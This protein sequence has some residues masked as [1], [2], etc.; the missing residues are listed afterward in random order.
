MARTCAS[1]SVEPRERDLRCPSE[2][3]QPNRVRMPSARRRNV[4][5]RSVRLLRDL[6]P[7]E[8]LARVFGKLNSVLTAS[9]ADSLVAFEDAAAVDWTNPHPTES[10]APATAQVG[11]G[12]LHLAWIMSPPGRESG[13]HQ[14]LFRFIDQAERHGH[15]CTI[16]L[17]DA[18]KASTISDVRATIESSDA[19]AGVAAD[20][21][22][23]VR[24]VGVDAD[25]DAI[26]ATGWETAYP[27]YLDA[28]SARRLYFVQD[29]EPSFYPM[30]SNYVLAENTYR[31]G[32]HGIT[33]G[34]W[35]AEKLSTEYGMA[36]DKFDFAVDKS[37]YWLTNQQAR[38]EVFFYARPVTARRAFEFGLMALS[39]FSRLRPDVTINFAGWHVNPVDVPFPFVNHGS[40][41]LKALNELYNRCAAGLVLSLTNMSLLPLELMSSGV[42][43]VV[44]DA[45][46]NRLVADN[47]FIE[48]VPLAPSV[49]AQRMAGV[50]ERADGAA[51]LTRMSASVAEANWD[52]S[53]DAFVSA[54]ERAVR[55]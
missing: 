8:F 39:E 34:G 37:K 52:D 10:A 40:L 36:T 24:S 19:Y 11:S 46:N 5:S 13:G 32:F 17:Y 55:G 6:G 35:L 54:V 51:R 53:G 20:I 12:G 7:R 43:P 23:Y 45:P 21:R 31:F 28:S 48:W 15:R 4:I 1:S 2:R 29:F 16:Y 25:T 38:S 27:S 26:I 18:H 22:V 9:K 33:A 3:C 44:N 41:E 30:G 50:L 14:N 49:I 42:V 47:E